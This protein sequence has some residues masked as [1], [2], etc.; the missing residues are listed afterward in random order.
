MFREDGSL[1]LLDRPFAVDFVSCPAVNKGRAVSSP[2]CTADGVNGAMRRR[3]RNVLS[4]S[5]DR[6]ASVLV[7]GAWGCGVF[8]NEPVDM[9]QN[10][11]AEL[12]DAQGFFRKAFGKIV[13][14]ICDKRMADIF[15]EI[16]LNE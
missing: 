16:L 7:L 5:A 12:D 8:K 3:I 1:G 6:K 9:A 15:R 11:R 2:G 10:F 13:F 4:V 14:A